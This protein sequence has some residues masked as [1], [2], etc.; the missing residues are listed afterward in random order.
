MT[1]K[2]LATSVPLGETARI[3]GGELNSSMMPVWL[4]KPGR[5]MSSHSS[6][7]SPTYPSIMGGILR[8]FCVSLAQ[9]PADIILCS[10]RLKHLTSCVI[11]VHDSHEYPRDEELDL[12]CQ[13]LI[14]LT[15]LRE[16][17]L[18]KLYGPQSSG[19]DS[20][21]LHRLVRHGNGLLPNLR[22]LIWCNINNEPLPV[23]LLD[24]RLSAHPQIRS[25][26]LLNYTPRTRLTDDP[27]TIQSCPFTD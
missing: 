5:M 4:P 27:W 22:H 14:S 15:E 1:L 23:A 7:T 18:G 21:I 9:Q 3:S 6:K 19:L 10:Q 12:V 2:R 13:G 11:N 17:D 24:F 16:L 26:A 8:N 20:K 25:V